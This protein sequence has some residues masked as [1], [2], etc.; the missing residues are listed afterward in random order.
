[1]PV[2]LNIFPSPTS[3]MT[4]LRRI[5]QTIALK[6]FSWNNNNNENSAEE[7]I[8][9]STHGYFD[10]VNENNIKNNGENLDEQKNEKI[11]NRRRSYAS[12]AEL[13]YKIV[14]ERIVKR[15]LLYYKGSRIGL[16]KLNDSPQFK[17]IKNDILSVSFEIWHEIDVLDETHTSLIQTMKKFNGYLKQHFDLGKIKIQL[18]KQKN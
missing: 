2:P 3:I 10:P 15:F 8:D 7:K 17:E 18:N 16:G 13:T 6:R 11:F 12:N 1:M 9:R 5:K 4:L 14:I